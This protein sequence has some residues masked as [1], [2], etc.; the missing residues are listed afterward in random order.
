MTDSVYSDISEMAFPVKQHVANIHRQPELD[1]QYTS[2]TE[3]LTSLQ[4]GAHICQNH[5]VFIRRDLSKKVVTVPCILNQ[6][7]YLKAGFDVK[8]FSQFQNLHLE[9]RPIS[10]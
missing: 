1:N 4:V 7:P 3:S 5:S 9:F 10:P 6:N 8:K 2:S